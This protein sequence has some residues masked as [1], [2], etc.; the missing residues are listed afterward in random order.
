MLSLATDCLSQIVLC[1]AGSC[2]EWLHVYGC[3]ASTDEGLVLGLIRDSS[4]GIVTELWTACLNSRDT[5]H[6]MA[7]KRPARLCGPPRLLFIGLFGLFT[8][9]GLAEWSEADR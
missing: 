4:V 9:G 6:G 2:Q 8:G 3:I 1:S 7:R 5:V